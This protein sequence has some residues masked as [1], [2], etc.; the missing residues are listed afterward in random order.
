MQEVTQVIY[1]FLTVSDYYNMYKPSDSETSGGGQKYVDFPTSAISVSKWRSFLSDVP[2]LSES[3][4]QNGP[5]WQV[6]VLNA[7]AKTASQAP[8]EVSVYQRRSATVCIAN[9]HMAGNRLPAWHPSNGFPQPNKP[10]ERSPVPSRLAVYLAKSTNGTIWAGWFDE[11]TVQSVCRTG[12]AAAALSRMLDQ[13][14]E[15]GSTGFITVR[16]GTLYLNDADEDSPVFLSK[17]DIQLKETP[18]LQVGTLDVSGF[19]SLRDVHCKFQSMNVL[20]GANGAGKSNLLSLFQLM[21]DSL[22]G[23][24]NEFV[25]SRGGAKTLLHLGPNTTEQISIGVELKTNSSQCILR[26]V[27]R[28]KP[29]DT[30]YC[31]EPLAEV[32]PETVGQNETVVDAMC[33]VAQSGNELIPPHVVVEEFRTQVAI[34]HLLDTSITS[35]LRQECYIDDNEKL[36]SDGSNLPAMLYLFRKTK[37]RVYGRICSTIRKVVPGF[38]DFVLEPK[39]MT[40]NNILLNWKQLGSD[41]ILGPH[42][43]SDGSL[44]TMALVTLLLQPDSELPNLIL[45][46]EPELGLHPHATA[47]IAGLIR[48]ASVKSQVIVCTQ[49]PTFVDEFLPEEIIVVETKKR[50]SQFRRLE[51]DALSSWLKE[52]SLGELWQKNV[53]GGGPV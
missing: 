36:R 48:A 5:R 34:L 53:I 47:M 26:Q 15:S 30:L 32:E 6:P 23:R 3:E 39:R 43:I 24:L 25:Q 31:I 46:D 44:R 40:P 8:V 14:N 16:A 27:F 17:S 41:Y 1:R 20:V 51:P 50:E 11:S 13:D 37:P 22:N 4:G 33:S 10:E 42:Q 28:Y 29:P 7:S 2:G 35:R 19:K 18:R 38:D 45:L 12:D 49:S 21:A 9:Q 52:Y